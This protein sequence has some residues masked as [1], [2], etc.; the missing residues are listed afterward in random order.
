MQKNHYGAIII[1]N[2]YRV[3]KVLYVVIIIILL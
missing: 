1:I 3:K 2:L